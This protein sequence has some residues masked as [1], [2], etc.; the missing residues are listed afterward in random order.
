[1]HLRGKK[2]NSREGLLCISQLYKEYNKTYDTQSYHLRHTDCQH[3]GTTPELGPEEYCL[4]EFQQPRPFSSHP[5]SLMLGFKERQIG[6]CN[7]QSHGSTQYH[8]F[9]L[10]Q[11]ESTIVTFT[12]SQ[13]S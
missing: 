1:M 11:L 4:K 2:T 9:E 12:L 13:P 10:I 8:R 6:D 7:V 3:N 5:L